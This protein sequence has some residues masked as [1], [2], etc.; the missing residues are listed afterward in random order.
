MKNHEFCFMIL[1]LKNVYFFLKIIP[2]YKCK[3]FYRS[4]AWLFQDKI[5]N[6]M[7][8]ILL[9]W[10]NKFIL[11]PLDQLSM[12]IYL[13]QRVFAD[14]IIRDWIIKSETDKLE[15]Y[16]WDTSILKHMDE[17]KKLLAQLSI[18]NIGKNRDGISWFFLFYR[19]K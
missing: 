5:L 9:Y 19:N 4:K 15:H 18:N 12:Q 17:L 8:E 11:K 3:N 10:T 1:F 2:Y 14:L 16:E 7:I 6:I 13:W